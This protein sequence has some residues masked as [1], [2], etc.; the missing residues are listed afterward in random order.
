MSGPDCG[1]G[2][3]GL[4]ACDA[5]GNSSNCVFSTCPQCK[6]AN[7]HAAACSAKKCASSQFDPNSCDP[8]AGKTDV[9]I[10]NWGSSTPPPHEACEEWYTNADWGA[11]ND[12]AGHCAD[13]WKCDLTCCQHGFVPPPTAT[14][15][16]E[17]VSS[18]FQNDTIA[19]YVTSAADAYG[20]KYSLVCDPNNNCK[21]S[22]ADGVGNTIWKAT[23]TSGE[24][25]VKRVGSRVDTSGLASICILSITP[26]PSSLTGGQ[27]RQLSADRVRL[28][29]G[30][31]EV[32]VRQQG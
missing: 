6:G 24:L 9:W 15:C 17:P 29:E 22:I 27:G 23:T 7:G 1:T 10:P 13:S 16:F 12:T 30:M 28:G 11:A 3:C 8:C 26:P 31:Q 19:G 21:E 20:N 18:G 2:Q 4:S 25:D 14:V 32:H 5:S